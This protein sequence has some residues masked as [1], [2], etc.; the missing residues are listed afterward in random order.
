MRTLKAFH[1]LKFG[2]AFLR[3]TP[4]LYR[5][6]LQIRVAGFGVYKSTWRLREIVRA[7]G[8]GGHMIILQMTRLHTYAKTGVCT[9]TMSYFGLCMNYCRSWSYEHP[10]SFSHFRVWYGLSKTDISSVQG[11]PTNSRSGVWRLQE[12]AVDVRDCSR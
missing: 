1:V 10:K 8:T 4:R 6:F 2:M 11:H 5:D 3:L 12:H 9:K 7:K